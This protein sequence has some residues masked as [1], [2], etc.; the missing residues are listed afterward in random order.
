MNRVLMSCGHAALSG[1]SDEPMCP[2]CMEYAR[3]KHTPELTDRKASCGCCGREAESSCSLPFFKYQP[4]R[5]IDEFY[6]GCKG[7]D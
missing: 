2:M 3:M 7:W 4:D 6:C 5:F 1:T